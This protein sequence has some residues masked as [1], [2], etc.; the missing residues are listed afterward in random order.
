MRI[1][2]IFENIIGLMD[3]SGTSWVHTI[4]LDLVNNPN[5]LDPTPP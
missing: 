4:F 1:G 2:A 5:A 3:N